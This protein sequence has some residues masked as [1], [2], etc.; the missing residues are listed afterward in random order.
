VV[1]DVRNNLGGFVNGHMLDVF[2]RKNFMTMTPR[3]LFGV[4]GR[5]NLGQ[6]ALGLPTVLVTNESSLSD[7][8]DFAEGYRALGLG[9]I[10]GVPTAGWLIYTSQTSLI[11]GSV[12]RVPFIR[13]DGADGKNMERNPRPVDVTVERQLGDASDTQLDAAVAEL[14]KG[15]GAKR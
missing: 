5:Q 2:S 8:E 9:K 3:G 4:P 13:I 7:A 11:D 14:L 10:V 12:F 15:L 6:R 1:I